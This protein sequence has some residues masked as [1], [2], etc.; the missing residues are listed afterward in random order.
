MSYFLS[1]FIKC[2]PQLIPLKAAKKVQMEKRVKPSVANFLKV[3][4]ANLKIFKSQ[5]AAFW[6]FSEPF[7][8]SHKAQ[9]C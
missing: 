5:Y 8:F 4:R 9:N 6:K 1:A 3:F 2:R 7:F